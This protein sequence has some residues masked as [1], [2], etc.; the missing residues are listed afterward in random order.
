MTF[1]ATQQQRSYSLDEISDGLSAAE[2]K[3]ERV[4]TGAGAWAFDRRG[5]QYVVSGTS[6]E[7]RDGAKAVLTRKIDNGIHGVFPAPRGD[8]MVVIAANAH[9]VTT[10]HALD[11]GGTELWSVSSPRGVF[12]ASWA[13]DSSRVIVS[14]SGGS[15]VVDGKT[16]KRV[17]ASSGWAFARS[18]ELPNASPA[19]AEAEFATP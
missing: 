4:A 14:A 15:I 2:M 10:A 13:A 9:G 8:R 19:G 6:I 16:G 3:K 18:T 7:I 1:D 5:R 17:I 11:D 12:S